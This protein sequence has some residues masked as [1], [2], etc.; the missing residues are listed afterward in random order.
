MTVVLGDDATAL[1]IALHGDMIAHGVAAND[2]C[3]RMHAFTAHMALDR[4]CGVNNALNVFFGIVSFFQV[5]VG[6]ERTIDG[7]AQLSTNKF[8]DTVTHGIGVVQNTRSIAHG[9]FCL[10]L[11]ERNNARNMVFTVEFANMF[12]N[13]LTMLIVE[14]DV[15]IGHLNTFR[16]EEAFEHQSVLNGVK[17]GDA[18]GVRAE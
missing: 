17:V 2:G 14:V 16:V 5:G 8:A 7:D 13:I 6:L 9:V 4:L 3:A 18:H 1:G 11:A 10:Q 12:D 15:D